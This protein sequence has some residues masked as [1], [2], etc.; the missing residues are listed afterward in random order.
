MKYWAAFLVAIVSLMPAHTS[1]QEMGPGPGMA[2]VTIIPGGGM[3][4]V[5]S[6][7]ESSFGNYNLGGAFTYNINRYV[8]VEGEVG[9]TLGITQ[10][11][12]LGG[13][14]SSQKT[15]NMLGYTGNVVVSAEARHGTVPYVTGGIGGLTMFQDTGLAIASNATFLTGNLGGGV[16][17]Y[18]N[19][20]VGFRGDYRFIM[21]R[22]TDT[23]PAFFGLENRY[24]HRVY[25]A[26]VLNVTP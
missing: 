22:S 12:T 4:F 20:R 21:V 25:G 7:T 6:N 17:W 9:G 1:A 15:P 10:N 8:G 3:F 26:L 24:G 16:K 2:E 18:A 5:S 11:L 23:A 19:N 13:V 14:T